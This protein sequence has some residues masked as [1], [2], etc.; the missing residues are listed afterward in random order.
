MFSQLKN[1][2]QSRTNISDEDLNEIFLLCSVHDYK[3][4]DVIIKHGGFC[5]VIGFLNKG[6]IRVGATKLDKEVT[7]QFIFEGCFFTYVPGLTEEKNV[8]RISLRSK[9]AK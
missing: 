8:K 5:S 1:Y 2:I 3:K 4:D 9:I 7:T 6:L